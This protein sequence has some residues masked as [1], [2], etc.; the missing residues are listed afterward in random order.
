LTEHNTRH[1]DSTDGARNTRDA[2]YNYESDPSVVKGRNNGFA[3]TGESRPLSQQF[4]EHFTKEWIQQYNARFRS[5]NESNLHKAD[6]GEQNVIDAL[7]TLKQDRELLQKE[8]L[9]IGKP[10]GLAVAHRFPDILAQGQNRDYLIEVKNIFYQVGYRKRARF[11]GFYEQP[12]SWVLEWVIDKEW[13][14]KEYPVRAESGKHAGKPITVNMQN[15]AP[16][17]VFVNSYPSFNAPAMAVLDAFF[18]NNLAFGYHPFLEPDHFAY[19]SYYRRGWGS[20]LL[21]LEDVLKRGEDGKA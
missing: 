21:K 20:M 1:T 5:R 17:K 14:A 9:L 12:Q 15:G 10:H 3:I 8:P 13:T 19:C 16:I 18:G 2:P 7:V 6:L 11:P 4:C